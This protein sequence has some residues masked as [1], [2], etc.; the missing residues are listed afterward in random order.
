[1][2]IAAAAGYTD[3]PGTYTDTLT[4]IATATF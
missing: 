4:F 1:M 2:D 3:N